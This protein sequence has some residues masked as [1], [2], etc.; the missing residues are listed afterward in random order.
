MR[1]VGRVAEDARNGGREL[2][3]GHDATRLSI[4]DDGAWTAIGRD[5]GR[6]PA[7]QRL[8]YHVAEGVGVRWK[9]EEVHVGIGLGESFSAQNSGEL[10]AM[11]SFAQPCFVAAMADYKETK[12]LVADLLELVLH[13]YQAG[14]VFLDREAADKAKHVIAIFRPAI[15]FGGMEEVGVDA[16]RHEEAGS[17]G[18]SFE[19]PAEIHV[20]RE[21]HLRDGV[22]L[23]GGS[24]GEIFDGLPGNGRLTRRQKAQEPLRTARRV[25]VHIRMPAGGDGKPH[26]GS[27]TRAQ[28]TDFAGSGDVNE[29]GLEALQDFI[30]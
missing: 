9:D 16:A 2:R 13:L 30:R 24:H 4:A 29:I 25:L 20:G 18:H 12:A 7:S 15:S 5:D 10:G 21:Q 11:Q 14:D 22:E 1:L 6:N 26:V 17:I 3:I 8:E 28:H 19:L 27:E 23:G